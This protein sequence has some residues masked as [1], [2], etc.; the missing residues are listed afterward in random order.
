MGTRSGVATLR[1]K[2][3]RWNEV[4][5]TQVLRSR[6]G[7]IRDKIERSPLSHYVGKLIPIDRDEPNLTIKLLGLGSN[8]P[9]S[10]E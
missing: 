7:E 8:P 5:N 6:L 1:A 2:A 10:D 3:S 9:S 4:K